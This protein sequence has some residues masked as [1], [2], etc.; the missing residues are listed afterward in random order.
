MPIS[1]IADRIGKRHIFLFG[2]SLFC[3]SSLAVY[4]VNSLYGLFLL[5]IL[6]GLVLLIQPVLM[7]LLSP[8]TGALSDRINPAVLASSGMILVP[9]KP[10]A[11]LDEQVQEFVRRDGVDV[12]PGITDGRPKN[13][14]VLAQ[15]VHGVY[16]LVEIAFAAA[17]VIDFTESFDTEGEAEIAYVRDFVAK[18]IINERTVGKSVEFTVRVFPAQTQDIFLAHERFAARE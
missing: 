12:F 17:A 11:L 15:E 4:F 6:Q 8:V 16:D 2:V 7:A 18:S 3:V 9:R 14:A 1:K 5:R 13:D 10:D